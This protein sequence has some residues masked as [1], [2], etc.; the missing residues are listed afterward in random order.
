MQSDKI[1][2][3]LSRRDLGTF[4]DFD[5][6]RERLRRISEDAGRAQDERRLAQELL[7]AAELGDKR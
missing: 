7:E 5:E 6:M 3:P 2:R 1:Y 4:L